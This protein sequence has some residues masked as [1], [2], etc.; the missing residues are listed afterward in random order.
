[1]VRV[2]LTG[3]NGFIASHILDVLVH[4]RYS[5]AITVRTKEKGEKVLARYKGHGSVDISIFVVPDF[6]VPGAFDDCFANGNAF[7]AV[8]HA[9]SPFKYS[10]TNIQKE[11]LDPAIV[12]TKLLLKAIYDHAE[13]VK[14]VV[15]TS[16]FAA[17][18]DSYKPNAI[19]HHTYDASQWNPLTKEDALKDT[20]NGYRASKLFAERAAWDFM[21]THKPAFSF[22][23]ICPTL[24]FGPITQP[25]D[26]PE[27]LNTSSQR[28]FNFVKGSCKS[29]MPDTGVS[30]FLWIDV[31]DLALAHVKAVELQFAA[32]ESRRYLLTAGYF[33]NKEV[34]DIIVRHF[35]KYKGVLPNSAGEGGFPEE[36]VYKFDDEQARNE[37][38]IEYTSLEKSVVDTVNSLEAR[39][40]V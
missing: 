23:S 39:G 6:T 34:C 36:G 35:G 12:G 13:S 10:V 2:L 11:L 7:D 40:Y 33:T 38:K 24:A 4:K 8:L 22:V 29:Q 30:F 31:R 16:S 37:L 32:P 19:P 25:L 14:T 26:G 3:G 5:V 18:L 15:L 21:D 20:L 9:A 28:V 1:M 27:A 17:I